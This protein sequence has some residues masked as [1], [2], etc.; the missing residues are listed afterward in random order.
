MCPI[1]TYFCPILEDLEA[2]I[3]NA[4]SL[5]SSSACSKTGNHYNHSDQIR[6]KQIGQVVQAMT[7]P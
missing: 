1:L 4:E 7:F 6:T 2:L 3:V 5:S